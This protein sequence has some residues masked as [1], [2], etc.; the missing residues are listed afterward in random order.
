M[1]L[2]LSM[3]YDFPLLQAMAANYMK[4]MPFWTQKGAKTPAI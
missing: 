3:S 1:V 2:L 4:W